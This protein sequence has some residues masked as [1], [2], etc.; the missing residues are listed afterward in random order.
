MREAVAI[1]FFGILL[2]VIGIAFQSAAKPYTEMR[3]RTITLIDAYESYNEYGERSLKGTALDNKL[4]HEFVVS[5]STQHYQQF[6]S[7]RQPIK[8]LEVKTS[9][10][11]MEYPGTPDGKIFFGMFFATVGVILAI[12]GV[13]V[14]FYKLSEYRREKAHR[15]K[16]KEYEKRFGW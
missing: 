9:L 11:R 6:M 12:I 1:F 4:N 5:L 7:N 13:I 3:T 16:Q 2:F 14:F 10:Q 15:V 8:G